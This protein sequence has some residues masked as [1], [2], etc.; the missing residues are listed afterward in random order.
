MFLKTDNA[1]RI[2]LIALLMTGIAL[3]FWDQSRIPAL[4]AK[5]QMGIRTQIDAIAFD[6]IFPALDSYSLLKRILFTSINWAYTN[7][8]GMTFGLLFGAACLSLVRLIPQRSS[9]NIFLNSLKGTLIGAPLGVCVNCS[10]PIMQGMQRGG[11]RLESVLST[12]SSSPTLNIIVLTM[13]FSILPL[14]FAV[15]KLLAVL[16]FVL[17]VVPLVVRAHYQQSDIS[18]QQEA[19]LSNTTHPGSSAFTSDESACDLNIVTPTQTPLVKLLFA[20]AIDYLKDIWFIA[21]IAVPFMLL[22]GVLGSAVIETVPLEGLEKLPMATWSL[23]LVALIGTFLPVPIALDVLLVSILISAGMP[24]AFAMVLLFTLGVFSVYPFMVIWRDISRRIALS[25]FT[26]VIFL[27]VTTGYAVDYY[28]TRQSASID[29]QYISALQ[30]SRTTHQ[31]E[32]E[33]ATFI[34]E[35]AEAQCHQLTPNKDREICTRDYI[36]HRVQASGDNSLCFGLTS[37]RLR[38]FCFQQASFLVITQ[39]AVS[40]DAPALCEKIGVASIAAFC[41]RK[42]VNESI[43]G[44]S[45]LSRCDLLIAPEAVNHCK[46]EGFFTRLRKYNDT[47]VCENFSPGRERT[48]CL[49]TLKVFKHTSGNNYADCKRLGT[50]RDQQLCKAMIAKRL[51]SAGEG[52]S[53]CDRIIDAKGYGQC[54][55]L[56]SSIKA[57]DRLDPTACN[58]VTGAKEEAQCRQEVINASVDRA[59]S[60]YLIDKAHYATKAQHSVQRQTQHSL[61]PAK[62]SHQS[63][64]TS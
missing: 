60:D 25:L 33:L 38:N 64:S 44:G 34:L 14:E 57:V 59:I 52:E 22:A 10:T 54:I 58:L 39:D 17:L 40:S 63:P 9:G 21:R 5:A 42:V 2:F 19:S 8:K 4:T 35:Q 1:K 29:E 31:V 36:L 11:M 24:T 7:W 61:L 45:P 49:G 26:G 55:S 41:K 27:G 30:H 13:S 6:V 53:H 28:Q 50:E 20:T 56:A 3:F 18:Q 62:R 12:L 43:S 37:N 15:A 46:L 48:A 16:F 47:N 32:A 51:V 23:V